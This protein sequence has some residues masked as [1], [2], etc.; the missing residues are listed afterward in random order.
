MKYYLIKKVLERYR[1]RDGHTIRR[2]V[3]SVKKSKSWNDK[4]VVVHGR[5]QFSF[6]NS[7]GR[8][9]TFWDSQRS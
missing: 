3:F 7:C 2:Q 9:N 5:S 1:P 8:L 4:R 6:E